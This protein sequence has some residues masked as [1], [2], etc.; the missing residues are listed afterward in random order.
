M[1][2]LKKWQLMCGI[3]L[4]TT[5]VFSVAFGVFMGYNKK[6][7]KQFTQQNPEDYTCELLC[8]TFCDK[9]IEIGP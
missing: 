8:P 4:V 9:K 3:F 5:L 2:E 6:S 7:C 1:E